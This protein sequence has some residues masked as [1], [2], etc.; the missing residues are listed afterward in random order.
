[1]GLRLLS[2]EGHEEFLETG[3]YKDAELK[4][5]VIA[6]FIAQYRLKVDKE[7]KNAL[8]NIENENLRY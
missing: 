4:A 8:K 6:V 3:E 2:K 5:E 1:M 7:I